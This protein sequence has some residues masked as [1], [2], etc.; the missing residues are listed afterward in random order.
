MKEYAARMENIHK[1]ADGEDTRFFTM[2]GPLVKNNLE[3]YFGVII[4]GT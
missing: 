2:A 3:K 1:H 4:R